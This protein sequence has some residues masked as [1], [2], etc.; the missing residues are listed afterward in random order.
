MFET[1]LDVLYTALAVSV[2]L[3]TVFI[4]WLLI[5]S[6]LVLHRANRLLRDVREKLARIDSALVG[7]KDKIE[8][9][10]GYLSLLAE[11]L[12]QIVPMIIRRSKDKKKR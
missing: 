6:A 1:S 8:H 11:G 5:E 9:S 10:A 3:L 4:V 12:K 2:L 7:I